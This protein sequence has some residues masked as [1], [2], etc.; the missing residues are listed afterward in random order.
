MSRPSPEVETL[1]ELLADFGGPGWSPDRAEEAY[2]VVKAREAG[3]AGAYQAVADTLLGRVVPL[4][5][6][7]AACHVALVTAHAMLYTGLL[8]N[9]GQPRRSGDAG[10]SHVHFGGTRGARREPRFTGTPATGI[11]AELLS[12]CSRLC[13]CR[14][15]RSDEAPDRAVRFYSDLS[16]VHPFYD[17]NGRAGRFVVSVYLHL[18]GWLVEWGRIEARE[19]E[20]MRRINNVTE[21]TTAAHDYDADLVR[22]WRRH[23]VRTDT[24]TDDVTDAFE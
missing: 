11:D 4:V 22:Y 13:D 20:F 24:F 10:G 21:K 23:V 2:D 14:D 18:H 5:G 15:S 6:F 17:G 19:G 3:L 7:P 8:T 1:R 16:R 12:A 9:A